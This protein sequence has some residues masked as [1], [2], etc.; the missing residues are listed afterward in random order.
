MHVRDETSSDKASGLSGAA[1]GGNTPDAPISPPQPE[2]TFGEF[3]GGLWS[4]LRELGPVGVLAF[5]W[6]AAPPLCSIPLFAYMPRIS[7]WLRSHPEGGLV[8]GPTVYAGAFAL[9]A[10]IGVLPTYAQSGLG[11]FAFGWQMGIPLALAGFAGA[12]VIGYGIARVVS[13]DRAMK[14]IERDKRARAVRDA[15]VKDREGG[16]SG[17]WKTTLMV[18]LLRLP[19]NSPFALSNLAMSAAKVPFVPFVVG[20]VLGMA[21][22]TA[23]AVVIGSLVKGALTEDTLKDAAPKW[24]WIVGIAVS[25]VVF[26]FVGW[27]GKRAVDRAMGTSG[28]GTLEK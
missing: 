17:W 7:E 14:L 4:L 26:V 22:R 19:P 13:G 28:S 23:L 25:L 3:V 20:T 6:T 2:Q 8:S 18:A 11:G 27:I 16:G 9:L 21:P 10:G 1:G 24:V 15:L 5:I 12:A